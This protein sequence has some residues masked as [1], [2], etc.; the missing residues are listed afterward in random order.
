MKVQQEQRPILRRKNVKQTSFSQSS[1][2]N[3][4]EDGGT[5]YGASSRGRNINEVSEENQE[6]D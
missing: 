5:A 6:E 3:N 4:N 2:N 1:N